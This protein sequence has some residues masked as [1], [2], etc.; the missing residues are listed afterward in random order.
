MYEEK[1]DKSSQIRR[2]I[3]QTLEKLQKNSEVLLHSCTSI[4][5]F[6]LFPDTVT[7]DPNK[8]DITHRIFFFSKSIRSLLIEDIRFVDV[9]TN[10]FFA[11]LHFEVVGYEKN[12]EP[13]RFLAKNDAVKAK[14]IITGLIAA[15]KKKI[16]IDAVKNTHLKKKMEKIG[17]RSTT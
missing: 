2:P 12:P 7:I 4:F 16:P 5:P 15:R 9:S 14:Q 13:I 17:T 6:T 11:S 10:L 8:V 3:K 1:I